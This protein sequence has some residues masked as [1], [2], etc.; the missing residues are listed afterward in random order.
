MVENAHFIKWFIGVDLKIIA[1]SKSGKVAC[2]FGVDLVLWIPRNESTVVYRID[3]IK[4]LAFNNDGSML[5]VG[6]K[7]M[8]NNSG[9]K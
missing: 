9:S 1:W 7:K 4:A 5:A 3:G 6:K 8:I 2:S